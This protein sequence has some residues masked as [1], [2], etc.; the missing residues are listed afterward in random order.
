M[1]TELAIFVGRRIRALRQK[2]GWRQSDL[3]NHA[4][5]AETHI[6]RIE[7]ARA[8]VCLDMLERLARSLDSHPADLLK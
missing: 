1:P 5:V 4:K 6:S 2:K 8:E 3:A 7:N